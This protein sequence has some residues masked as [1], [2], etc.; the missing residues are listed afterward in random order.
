MQ[1]LVLW[2]SFGVT[3]DLGKVI[4]FALSLGIFLTPMGSYS[5]P[6]EIFKIRTMSPGKK[7][8]TENNR[9]E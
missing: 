8:E 6:P 5:V 4:S 2:L 1:I 7:K 9:V 3:L